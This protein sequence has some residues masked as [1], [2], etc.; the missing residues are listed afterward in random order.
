M[1]EYENRWLRNLFRHYIQYLYYRRKIS[2][3]TFGWMMEVIPSRGYRTGVRLFEVDLELFEKTLKHLEENHGHYHLYSLLMYYSDI[4]LEHAVR[5]VTTFK[6]REIAYVPMLDRE[7]Q[8]GLPR[9]V[10]LVAKGRP[11]SFEHITKD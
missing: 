4:R 1:V 9:K 7:P 6:P 3:E 10:V 2:P 5:L 8:A 11:Q